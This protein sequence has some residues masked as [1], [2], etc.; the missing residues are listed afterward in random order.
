MQFCIAYGFYLCKFEFMIFQ[1]HWLYYV[2][3]FPTKKNLLRIFSYGKKVLRFAHPWKKIRKKKRCASRI[4]CLKKERKERIIIETEN[5]SIYKLYLCLFLG[6]L[7]LE[8]RTYR[9]KAEYS[10]IELV[11]LF[12]FEKNQRKRNKIKGFHHEQIIKQQ[13]KDLL[14]E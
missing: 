4:H 1:D 11:T 9:L 5:F 2:L 6:Y 3:F 10:T 12:S 8:P 13:L 7:G 14:Q